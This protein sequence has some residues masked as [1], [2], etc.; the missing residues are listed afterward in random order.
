MH[1]AELSFRRIPGLSWSGRVQATSSR[2]SGFPA[3]PRRRSPSPTTAGA[4][5]IP[6]K[7]SGPRWC[8]SATPTSKGGDVDDRETVAARLAVRLGVPVAN[9]G[10]AG[11][12]T[13]QELRV[14]RSDALD[15]RP[16]DRLGLLRGERPLRRPALRE[17]AAGSAALRGGADASS[18]GIGRRA[19]VVAALL[20]AQRGTLAAPPEPPLAPNRAPYWAY[21]QAED[22]P[23][24][25][26]YFADYAAVRWTDYERGAGEPPGR[27]SRTGS[28][29]RARGAWRSC[30][31]ARPSSSGL[32][33]RPGDSAR[34][35]HDRLGRLAEAPVL[36]AEFCAENGVRC[37][38][39][40]EPFARRAGGVRLR[41]HRHA[42]GAGGARPGGG[43]ARAGPRHPAAGAHALRNPGGPRGVRGHLLQG[44]DTATD[45]G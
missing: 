12:G 33:G 10:V 28:R 3:P 9:L 45:G 42:L 34:E 11:Y 7:W 16:G 37:L 44:R 14:V 23:D 31:L 15:R 36:F 25:R 13:L 1:D 19:R 4:T 39:L 5:G 21:R 17:L 6:S 24:A 2:P 40:S 27:L 38:D 22:G 30:S 41:A 29:R 26:I 20:P 18:R 35:P 8:W 43:R 32:P